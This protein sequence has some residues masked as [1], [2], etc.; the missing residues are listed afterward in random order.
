MGIVTVCV[1]SLFVVTQSVKTLFYRPL[2]LSLSLSISSGSP[3]VGSLSVLR[4]VSIVFE[5]GGGMLC[6]HSVEHSMVMVPDRRAAD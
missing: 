1:F 5:S 3:F 6:L 4:H 2:S